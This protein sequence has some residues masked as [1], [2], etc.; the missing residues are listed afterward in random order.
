MLKHRY[1]HGLPLMPFGYLRVERWWGGAWLGCF[2][3]L[4]GAS[5]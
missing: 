3:L 2:D 4:A 5:T 1:N